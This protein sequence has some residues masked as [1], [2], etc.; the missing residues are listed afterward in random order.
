MTKPPRRNNE[1]SRPDP[2]G[3]TATELVLEA[4]VDELIAAGW[5][6]EEI[7]AAIHEV[8]EAETISQVENAKLD[9]DLAII[10]AMERAK[11]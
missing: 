5:T 8:I 7:E 3:K 4:L 6:D 9:A 1:R 2:D 11:R 10:R